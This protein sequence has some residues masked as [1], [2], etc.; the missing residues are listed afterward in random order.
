[1]QLLWSHAVV[2][3]SDMDEM[4]DFY[5]RVMGFEVTDRGPMRGEGSPEIV[6]LSQDPAHHHQLAF[7]DSRT[8]MSP[9]NNVNHFAF[10]VAELADVKAMIEALTDDGRATKMAPLSHGNAWSVYFS[11]P[12]GNGIEVF[13]DSPFHVAQPQGKPWDTSLDEDALVEWTREHFVDEPE[14]GPIDDYYAQRRTELADR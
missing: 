2:Y 5:S 14:F 13:C 4:L 9:S 12:E 10:K 6:F 1:M 3:V 11:D 8:E 7:V